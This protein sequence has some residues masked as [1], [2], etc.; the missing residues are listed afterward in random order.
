MGTWRCFGAALA[1]LHAGRKVLQVDDCN[2]AHSAEAAS[3]DEWVPDGMLTGH[4]NDEPG[5]QSLAWLHWLHSS[6]PGAG[7][8]LRP[9]WRCPGT[10][11]LT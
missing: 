3:A 8:Q 6:G 4:Q 2:A 1:S 9:A 10:Q 5:A 11:A 7:P